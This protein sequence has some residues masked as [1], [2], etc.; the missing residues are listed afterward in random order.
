MAISPDAYNLSSV[1][2]QVWDDDALALEQKALISACLP[3]GQ[4]R[5]VLEEQLA[6]LQDT[7]SACEVLL[8]VRDTGTGHWLSEKGQQFPDAV[9]K[10][11][12]LVAR[13]MYLAQHVSGVNSG[14]RCALPDDF[15]GPLIEEI[16]S[17]Q[18]HVA[19]LNYDGLLSSALSDAGVLGGDNPLLFDGF[20]DSK[21]DRT[22]LF[23]KKRFGAWYLHL[24]GGPLFVDRGK[25]KPYKLLEASLSRNPKNVGRHIVLTHFTHKPKIIDHSE[26]LSIYW[27]FLAMAVEESSEVVM[28]GYSGN[29]LH[30]N[31]LIAQLRGTKP[32]RVVDWLGAGNRTTRQKFWNEQFGVDVDLHLLEDVLTFKD[33]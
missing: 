6:T 26:L 30:L 32:I 21:F 33:W 24:H 22:N 8:S 7:V 28:F 20:V 18:S 14:V 12:F 10:F 25:A 5:P 15:L 13:R 19:T 16:I 2:S 31:R 1:M 3:D 17:S 23:R 4:S 11:A 29:D 9:H 27:E